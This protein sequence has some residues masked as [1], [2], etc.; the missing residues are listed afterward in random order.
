MTSSNVPRLELTTVRGFACFALVAY[1]VVG[2]DATSGMHLPDASIWHRAMS[3][4]DFFRMPLFSALSGYIYAMN[5]VS[6]GT[7]V[8][9]AK[10]KAARLGF[11]LFFATTVM[12]IL[13]RFAYADSTNYIDAL[14]FHYQH[15]W[16]IQA[17]ILI[18]ATVAI[19]DA[20]APPNWQGLCIAAF[21]AAMISRSMEVT[22]FFS[23]GGALF[24][25]PFFLFGMVLHLQPA[26]LRRADLLNLA[27]W[28][29]GTVMILHQLALLEGGTPVPKNSVPAVFCGFCAA[30]LMFSLCPRVRLFEFVGSFSFTI[31][32]WHSI[33]ASAVRQ[34]LLSQFD[35][36]LPLEFAVLLC[37]GLIVPIAIHL[38]VQRI[39]VLCL[40][41][42]GI[43]KP[44][45]T[46][47][48][49]SLSRQ[50]LSRG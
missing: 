41:V 36:A 29:A 21:V 8:E 12:F 18:F 2:P 14:A 10:K 17:L 45:S 43:R 25:A 26:L 50:S 33:A 39:P 44:V 22:Q 15:L 19:W 38:A 24:L 7:V 27:L 23:L 1:H 31:Y 5:R 13:R 34:V 48:P 3:L 32:L 49:F 20:V 9:F 46:P 37:V 16:F 47:V 42:A 35:M 28:V 6:R 30:Y 11:P 40:L 4:F